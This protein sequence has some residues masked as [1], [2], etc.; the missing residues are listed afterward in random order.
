MS[1]PEQ[2]KLKTEDFYVVAKP[3]GLPFNRL[4]VTATKKV[5]KAVA[6]NRFK[7]VAREFFRLNQAA[8]PPGFDLLFIALKGRDPFKESSLDA[9]K[10]AFFLTSL[11]KRLK[12]EPAGPGTGHGLNNG[13]RG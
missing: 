2:S 4:G 5:G 7:R 9:A 12:R 8:W 13:P 1:G 3:N 6:R 10:F 11:A